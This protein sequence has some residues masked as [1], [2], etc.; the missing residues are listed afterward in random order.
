MISVKCI[1]ASE[2]MILLL[3]NTF[4]DFFLPQTSSADLLLRKGEAAQ[5]SGYKLPY[6]ERSILWRSM[7]DFDPQYWSFDTNFHFWLLV[8]IK[9][10]STSRV[11]YTAKIALFKGCFS[12]LVQFF[13]SI[14]RACIAS[15]LRI[16]Q[17]TAP[18]CPRLQKKEGWDAIES[19]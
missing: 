12:N 10:L 17:I 2:R 14:T 1:Y 9:F 4:V 8:Y 19:F 18:E 13:A 15:R 3:F 11:L 6:V 16:S 5:I 7:A